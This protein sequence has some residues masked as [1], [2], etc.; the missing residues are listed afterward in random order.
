MQVSR[1][2]ERLHDQAREP[3]IIKTVRGKGYV[4]A[5]RVEQA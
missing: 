1:L 2:R 4:L 3:E 5:V